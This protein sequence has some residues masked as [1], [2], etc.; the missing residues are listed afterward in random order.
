MAC[1]Y[2]QRLATFSV[3]KNRSHKNI[4]NNGGRNIDPCGTPNVISSQE[5]Y[6]QFNF[7]LCIRLLFYIMVALRY[8]NQDKGGVS[9]FIG[10]A[11]ICSCTA[12]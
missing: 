6:S 9:I 8:G 10:D 4:L 12:A 1:N 3:I 7:V 2:L 11:L 5:L